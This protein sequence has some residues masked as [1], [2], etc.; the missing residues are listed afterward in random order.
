METSCMV[1]NMFVADGDSVAA[2]VNDGPDVDDVERDGL[3]MKQQYLYPPHH[4]RQR[5]SFC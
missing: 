1:N 5:I 4:C 2:A 3:K